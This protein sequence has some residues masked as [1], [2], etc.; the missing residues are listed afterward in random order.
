MNKINNNPLLIKLSDFI[1]GLDIERLIES[2]IEQIRM[3][4]IYVSWSLAS[5]IRRLNVSKYIDTV[6]MSNRIDKNKKDR[7]GIRSFYRK[8]RKYT[9]RNWLCQM[10]ST[11]YLYLPLLFELYSLL[12]H[13]SRLYR[14]WM[15]FNLCVTLLSLWSTVWDIHS[16]RNVLCNLFSFDKQTFE[17]NTFI[18]NCGSI[19]ILL[20]LC[21]C[22]LSIYSI[23][24]I[25]VLLSV[26]IVNRTYNNVKKFL[27]SREN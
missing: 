7:N 4:V 6:D 12:F 25:D 17:L 19:A 21:F 11:Y 15:V 16:V 13:N 20:G 2:I 18:K 23:S 10:I 5:L 1:F 8:W 27:E 24:I 26:S 9:R 14:L 3:F 22:G